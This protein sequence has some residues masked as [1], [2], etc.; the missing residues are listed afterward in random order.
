MKMIIGLT[1]GI[2]SGKSTVAQLL[3]QHGAHIIDTDQVARD[4]VRSGS[5]YLAHIVLHFG[6]DIMLPNGQ[7]DRRKLRQHI[8]QNAAARQWLEALIHP[9]IRHEVRR[10]LATLNGVIAV[11]IPLLKNRSTYPVDTI[12]TVEV[13]KPLQITRIMQRYHCDAIQAQAIIATQPTSVQRQVLSDH[14]IVNNQDLIT[15]Q[16]RIDQLWQQLPC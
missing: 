11:V 10:Q 12:W 8:F 7:L 3:T 16:R 9:A 13:S 1:G 2:A 6:R 14:V 15:L 4:M 5:S